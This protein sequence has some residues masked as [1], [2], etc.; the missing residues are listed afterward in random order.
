MKIITGGIGHPFDIEEKLYQ[1]N[2]SISVEYYHIWSII[3]AI[4]GS[5][6]TTLKNE[7]A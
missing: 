2:T 4:R 7:L 3:D 6:K 5:I 1:I